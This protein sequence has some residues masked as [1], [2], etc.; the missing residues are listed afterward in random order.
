MQTKILQENFAKALSFVSRFSSSR[1]QLPVLANI[2]LKASKTKLTISA[3][4]LEVSA[5]SAIGAQTEKEGEITVPARVI[6]DIISSLSGGTITLSAEAEQ[7]KIKTDNFSGS[8]LGMGGAD[9]PSVPGALD[10]KKTERISQTEFTNALSKVIF[11]SSIDESRP[12][13]TGTL[14]V[15][16]GKSLTFVATDGFRLSQKKL[17]LA[18]EQKNLKKNVPKSGLREN[19]KTQ[20]RGGGVGLCFQ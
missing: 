4:N 13:L 18:K 17:T 3:T 11:A 20:G 6:T 12:T 5:T 9:F 2:L 19:L 8:V 16:E 10:P 15:F 14:L 7:L 1:A